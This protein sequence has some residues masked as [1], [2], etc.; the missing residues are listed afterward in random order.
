MAPGRFEPG[1]LRRTRMAQVPAAVWMA[2]AQT[3]RV[4]CF[5]SVA[6]YVSGLLEDAAAPG[7]AV[8]YFG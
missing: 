7:G 1:E 8:G 6:G 2:D 5:R 4:I 3:I